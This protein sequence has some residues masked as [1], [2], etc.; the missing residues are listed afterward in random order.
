M[1][2]RRTVLSTLLMS[3]LL[4]TAACSASVRKRVVVVGAG[5][6]GLGAAVALRNA[7]FEVIVVEARNR[8]GGRIHT[9]MRWP[10]LPVDLGASWIHGTK[11]NPVEVLARQAGVTMVKTSYDSTML[12]IHPDLRGLG[13]KDR[14]TD[15]AEAIFAK[16]MAWAEDR[17][18][19]VSVQAAL[20]AVAPRASLDPVRRSQLDFYVSAA[21]EQEYAGGAS[22][23]SAWSAEEG[24]EF[25][26]DDALFPGGYSQIVAHLSKGL[27]IRLNHIVKSVS[28]T[29][30]RA[31]LGLADGSKIHADNILVTVPLGV[32]KA[33]NIAFDPPLSLSKQQAIEKLGMGLLNK[34]WL[35]FDRVFWPKNFDWHEFLSARK[36][37]WSEW[38]SLAKIQNSPVLMVFS[39]ADNA[40]QVER[41]DDRDI[42]SSIMGTARQMFGNSI[43]E[44]IDAQITRWRSDPFAGGSYSF[45]AT[46]SGLLDRKMLASSEA[47]RL[48]FAGEAQSQLFPGTV[49]GALISG[50]DAAARIIQENR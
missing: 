38:V 9:S 49:H 35:R 43:P 16:A 15:G 10:D 45:Y 20:E 18:H 14:G 28:V 37:E 44:P 33:A 48:H 25:G 6:A 50:R 1:I 19:D 39:A 31:A 4:P 34:H 30:N 32:L 7:G 22:R 46:G 3:S 24:E 5:I 13:V 11:G 41:M 12:H 42:I 2:H 8:I 47:G 36:G 26:G 29:P 27:D 17:D 21:Y 23:L 40:E